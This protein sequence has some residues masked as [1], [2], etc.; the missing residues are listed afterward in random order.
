MTTR[1]RKNEHVYSQYRRTAQSNLCAFCE[2]TS[3]TERV[4][5]EHKNFWL[6]RNIYGYDIWENLDV[7]EHLMLIPKQHLVS[8]SSLNPAAQREYGTLLSSYESK[9]YSMY[10]RAA[11]NAAKSVSHQHT[12]LLKLDTKMKKFYMFLRKPY[13]LW[14][15]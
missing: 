7:I 13:M 5:A 15:K 8:L 12:H 10:I 2:F 4:V 3:S 9:G 6:V 11:T 1:K 14:Y